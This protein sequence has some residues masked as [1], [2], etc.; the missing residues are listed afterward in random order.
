M[1]FSFGDFLIGVKDSRV[2]GFKYFLHE[3]G[4]WVKVRK[5]VWSM[6]KGLWLKD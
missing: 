4:L 1:L 2:Q 3:T 6:V 5:P